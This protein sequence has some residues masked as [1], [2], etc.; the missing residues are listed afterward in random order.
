MTKR[1]IAISFIFMFAAIAW[2]VLGGT[3]FSRTYNQGP[4]AEN[5]VASTW[6]SEQKQGPPSASFKEKL[7]KKQEE[8]LRQLAELDSKNVTPQRKSFFDK[9][10]GLFKPADE[11]AP[12]A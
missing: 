11:K 5:R 3:I 7:T 8:L 9:V 1:I 10:K 2:A 6:G 4:I 12:P